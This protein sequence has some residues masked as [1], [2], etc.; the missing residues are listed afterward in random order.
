MRWKLI[1]EALRTLKLGRQFLFDLQ[2]NSLEWQKLLLSLAWKRLEGMNIALPPRYVLVD[3]IEDVLL[4]DLNACAYDVEVKEEK[5][6]V[7][8]GYYITVT[9]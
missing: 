5:G 7:V 1:G 3:F 9:K 2:P 4:Q 6:S 8:A